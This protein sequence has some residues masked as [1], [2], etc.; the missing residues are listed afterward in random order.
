M[1]LTRVFHHFDKI[2][3]LSNLAFSKMTILNVTWIEGSLRKLSIYSIPFSYA[4]VFLV[5]MAAL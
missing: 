4:D 5:N 1:L 2:K 3:I